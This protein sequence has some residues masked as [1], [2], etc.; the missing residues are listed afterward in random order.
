MDAAIGRF[1]TVDPL[2]EKY[3]SIS[4]YVYCANNPLRFTDP[5]GMYSTEQWKKD[6]GYTDDD[7][8]K[9]YEAPS[10]VENGGPDDP[11]NKTN[12]E[13]KTNGLISLILWGLDG[14]Q[15]VGKV[16][17]DGLGKTEATYGENLELGLNVYIALWSMPTMAKTAAEFNSGSFKFFS[18]NQNARK[19]TINPSKF[20]YFFGKVSSSTHNTSRSVQNLKDLNALGIF[21]DAQLLKYFDKA[22]GN[23]TIR[24]IEGNPY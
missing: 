16:I 18:K 9:V 7:F 6:N 3:Y 11:P 8:Y 23:P 22:Y 4:P 10:D 2:A 20:D 13:K 24:T 19:Y 17:N 15:Q 21:D 1:T 5:T 14:H 12:D